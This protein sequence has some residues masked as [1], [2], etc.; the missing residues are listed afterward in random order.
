MLIRGVSRGDPHGESGSTIR[1]RTGSN[2]E[3]VSL[4]P[5][6]DGGPAK[7]MTPRLGRIAAGGGRETRAYKLVLPAVF[8]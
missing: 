1:R 5:A 7:E 4:G 2:R 3:E 6:L 8:E